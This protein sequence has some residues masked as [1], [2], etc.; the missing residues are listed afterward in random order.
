ML[1]PTAAFRNAQLQASRSIRIVADRPAV[2]A[3]VAELSSTFKKLSPSLEV[4]DSVD[5]ASHILV[6]LSKGVLAQGSAS[7]AELEGVITPRIERAQRRCG[8]AAD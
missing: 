7:I 4:V 1:P 6:V 2:D 5:E 8:A 3:L